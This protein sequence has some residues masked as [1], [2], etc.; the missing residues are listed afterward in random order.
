MEPVAGLVEE[1]DIVVTRRMVMLF[2]K[3]Q[4]PVAGLVEQA[5]LRAGISVGI[6]E[7]PVIPEQ[8]VQPV[9]RVTPAPQVVPVIRAVREVQLLQ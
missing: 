1:A 9:Q 2:T 5:L 3:R 7:L 4:L 6:R 8:V